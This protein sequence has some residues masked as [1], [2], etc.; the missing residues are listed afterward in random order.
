MHDIAPAQHRRVLA[1]NLDNL[2]LVGDLG[3]DD[4]VVLLLEVR[5]E[6]AW[7]ISEVECDLVEQQAHDLVVY[8][9]SD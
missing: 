7:I 9:V 5:R 1:E 8:L 3:A 6:F 4:V 2:G